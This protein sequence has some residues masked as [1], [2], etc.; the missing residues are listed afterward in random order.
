MNQAWAFSSAAKSQRSPTELSG[1]RREARG[2]QTQVM[3]EPGFLLTSLTR[4]LRM[5]PQ[6]VTNVPL[7]LL[8]AHPRVLVTY[9]SENSQILIYLKSEKGKERIQYI[10]ERL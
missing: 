4:G 3:W 9:G 5:C 10:P 2:Q 8:C 1:E 7:G 6:P